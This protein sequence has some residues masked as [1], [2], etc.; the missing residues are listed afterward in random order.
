MCVCY[1]AV[2]LAEI[3]I[4]IPTIYTN[5]EHFYTINTINKINTL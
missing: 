1:T 4:S 5:S 3:T 2:T